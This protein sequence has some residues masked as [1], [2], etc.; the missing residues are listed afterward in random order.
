MCFCRALP[1]KVA[2]SR[3]MGPRRT[4][5]G[6][7]RHLLSHLF[8][9]TDDFR[10]WSSVRSPSD[11][12]MHPF[13]LPLCS[14]AP[15]RVCRSATDDESFVSEATERP[16]G[17][18][19]LRAEKPLSFSRQHF[20]RAYVGY[21]YSRERWDDAPPAVFGLDG[22]VACLGQ[23]SD[24]RPASMPGNRLGPP[25]SQSLSGVSHLPRSRPTK[26]TLCFPVSSRPLSC[27]MMLS[28]VE[29]ASKVSR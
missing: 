12:S 18:C 4:R 5:I 3:N 14:E 15:A 22:V 29:S 19:S 7:G 26:S 2:R 1:M 9:S 23:V 24:D 27:P 6:L 8:E 28:T 13:A 25:I 10:Q 11:I 16:T 21:E 20:N 17:Y